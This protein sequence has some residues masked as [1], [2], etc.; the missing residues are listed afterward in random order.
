MATAG[1][2]AAGSAGAHA[3]FTSDLGYLLGTVLRTYLKAT[4]AVV[5][6]IPGGARGFQV[7][8]AAV[9]G[10]TES[11]AGLAQRLGIDRTVMTYLLYDLE[12][13]GLVT[14]QPDP[15][16]RRNRHVVPTKDGRDLHDTLSE[17]LHAVEEH[18]LAALEPHERTTLRVL[19]HRL[20]GQHPVGPDSLHAAC[21]VVTDLAG[22][23]SK[24]PPPRRRPKARSSK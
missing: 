3:S 12:N 21:E 13:A 10:V 7:V 4:D 19:L 16:D 1:G 6:E 24:A 15:A 23:V 18:V 22:G 8:S 2:S 5:E 11:Q 14:R 9:S 20:A 17:K